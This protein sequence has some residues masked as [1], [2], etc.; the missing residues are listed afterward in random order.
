MLSN[1][2]FKTNMTKTGTWPK[3][4]AYKY[5]KQLEKLLNFVDWNILASPTLSGRTAK[6]LLITAWLS[7]KTQ[8]LDIQSD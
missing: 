1:E 5:M 6:A 8:A 4:V 7:F 3:L 2:H